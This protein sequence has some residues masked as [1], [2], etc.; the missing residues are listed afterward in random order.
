MSTTTYEQ[1]GANFDGKKTKSNLKAQIA[2]DPDNVQLYST[3]VVGSNHW[4]GFASNLPEGMEF[5][6]VGPDPY[7]ARDWYAT[8]YRNGYGVVK[9]K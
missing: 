9:C 3:A 4:S 8:V 2:N 7:T 1:G 6:V 5:N